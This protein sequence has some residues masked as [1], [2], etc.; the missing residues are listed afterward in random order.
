MRWT[1][2]QLEVP[3]ALWPLWTNASLSHRCG[4]AKPM[5]AMLNRRTMV[6]AVTAMTL[7]ITRFSALAQVDQKLT[8]DEARTLARDAW[9]FGMPLVYIDKQIDALTHTTKPDGHLA[10]IN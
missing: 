5:T 10:P 2:V 4:K 3:C 8:P 9:V 7:P 1:E 6:L